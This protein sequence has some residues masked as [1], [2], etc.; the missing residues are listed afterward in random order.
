MAMH[1]ESWRNARQHNKDRKYPVT[2]LS[3]NL[4]RGG[5]LDAPPSINTAGG[6]TPA[7][8]LGPPPLGPI[9]PQDHA[10]WTIRRNTCPWGRRPHTRH[11]L[12]L[13]LCSR[14]THNNNST[15]TFGS[16]H[17]P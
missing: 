6:P 14:T 8:L 3:V 2:Y 4:C 13:A 15:Y 12:A 9:P 10:A 17:L 11:R 7:Q 1:H 5:Y 16:K